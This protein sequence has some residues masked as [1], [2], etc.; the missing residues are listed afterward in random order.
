MSH[1]WSNSASHINLCFPIYYEKK[2]LT[3]SIWLIITK[4]NPKIAENGRKS[5][6]VLDNWLRTGKNDLDDS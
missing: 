2:M 6:K 4:N 3:N 5:L 1:F